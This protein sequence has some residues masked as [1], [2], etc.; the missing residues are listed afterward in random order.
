MIQSIVRAT[1]ILEILSKSNKKY[2]LAQI[3][4]YTNLPSSTIH[5][6]LQ[7]L[8]NKNYVV[9][10]EETHLYY[11]GPALIPLGMKAS[12]NIEIKNIAPP[13]LNELTEETKEDSHLIIR[14]GY[15]G[16]FLEKVEGSHPLKIVDKYG[17][18]VDLHCGA[19]RKVLLAYQSEEFIDEYISR[20][21]EKYSESTIINPN[22]LRKNLQEI[23]EEGAI[24]SVGEYIKDAIG[25][26]APVRNEKGEVIASIG[27][28]APVSRIK[29]ADI[30]KYKEIIKK[31]ANKIS[32]KLGYCKY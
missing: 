29:E 16:L 30:N 10:D 4:E 11:L 13:I 2:S 23:R 18:E 3:R 32:T 14:S 28:I 26:G 15:K 5:R 31:Y 12:S 21:L 6:I 19:I 20:G 24:S 7:T 1:E 22:E 17:P 25:I 9:K 8:C 27:I